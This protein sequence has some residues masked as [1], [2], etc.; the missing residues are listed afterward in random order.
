MITYIDHI[1][2]AVKNIEEDIALYRDILGLEVE[3]IETLPGQ[4]TRVVMIPVGESRVELLDSGDP[5][6]TIGR[7]LARRGEGVHHIAF[8][9]SDISGMLDNLKEKGI[10][11]IDKE[12]RVG[13]GGSKI[14]FLHP[15]K[16]KVLI[17]LVE[18]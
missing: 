9:V 15:S 14:A 10:P 2:I 17:E 13:A 4:K 3:E 16:T 6:D 1:G 8:G 12:P 11:L 5:D 7:F 18:R